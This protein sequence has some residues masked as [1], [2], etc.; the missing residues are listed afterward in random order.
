M[1]ASVMPRRTIAGCRASEYRPAD[2]P[3]RFISS[4]QRSS[5][6]SPSCSAGRALG[7]GGSSRGVKPLSRKK[8]VRMP[9]QMRPSSLSGLG[10]LEN[11]EKCCAMDFSSRIL[12]GQS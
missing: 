6:R 4:M 2:C 1:R 3:A 12:P 7:D 10:T 5:A 9:C 8:L 11:S